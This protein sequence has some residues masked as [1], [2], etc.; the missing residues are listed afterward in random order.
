MFKV[1]FF[2]LIS[3]ASSALALDS[4]SLVVSKDFSSPKEFNTSFETDDSVMDLLKSKTTVE[5]SYSGAFVTSINEIPE[6]GAKG[7]DWFYYVNGIQA[8]VGALA[9]NIQAHDHVW[10]DYHS[11]KNGEFI[12]AV[13]GAYPQ[14]FLS[15]Y[16]GNKKP[17]VIRASN[18]VN[19]KAMELL[20][21]LSSFGVQKAT[22]T[23]FKKMDFSEFEFQIIIGQ[24][25]ELSKYPLVEKLY[26]ARNKVG[27]VVELSDAGEVVYN[28]N[29]YKNAAVVLALNSAFQANPIWIITGSNDEIVKGIINK[30]V[31]EPTSIK[32]LAAALFTSNK[33]F[34]IPGLYEVK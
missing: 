10:W 24:W 11:W 2:I 16:A 27:F 3:T 23:G 31:E 25:Q 32:N 8:Q 15:G 13:I 5:T 22:L 33:L 34:S 14:P 12:S 9:Y 18:A 26:K 29:T 17:T 7:R 19:N 30:I 28:N 1:L 4:V 6:K 20:A 21:S